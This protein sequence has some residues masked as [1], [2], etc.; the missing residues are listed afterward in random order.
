MAHEGQHDALELSF[1]ELAMAYADARGRDELLNAGGD[2]VN[3]FDAIVDEVDLTA[4]L[5]LHFNSGADELF[6]EFCDHSLNGHAIF[7]RSFNDAHVAQA[8]ERHVEGAR[9]GRGAH[10]EHVNL[11]AHLLEPLLVADAE[12][13]LFIDDE[14]A[15][16]LEL[17]V[18]GK[19]AVGANEN[20]D[21]AGFNALD[22][23][24]LLLGRA[25]TRN[26]FDVDG[27]LGEPFFEGLKVLKA[28]DGSGREHGDLF[29]ILHCLECRTHGDFS[30]AVAHIAA[31]ETVHG[32]RGLHVELD[33]P[34]GR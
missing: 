9:N 5:Q 12:T 8:D 14:K 23:R 7:G 27:E 25:E 33:G 16:V 19:N 24:L 26:H 13:L 21:L 1:I 28:E 30:F 3:G 32:P 2:F 15:K 4:A 34:D 11:L 20:V 22:N 29:A 31:E 17:D 6:I 10:G 18:L